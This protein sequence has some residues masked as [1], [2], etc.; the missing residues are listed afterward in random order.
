MKRRGAQLGQL[1]LVVV[2]GLFAGC[3]G[4]PSG[5]DR[6]PASGVL[7]VQPALGTVDA[8]RATELAIHLRDGVQLAADA[9]RHVHVFGR[10]SG[11]AEVTDISVRPGAS[12]STTRVGVDLS[13]SFQA[14]ERVQVTIGAP[15]LLGPGGA[16]LPR[17]HSWSFWTATDP[18]SSGEL[19]EVGRVQVR[20]G[21][22]GRIQ[23]YGGYAGDLDGDGVSDL[24]VPNERSADIRV[25]PGQAGGGF[26]EPTVISVPDGARPS[27]TAGGDFDGDGQVD[28]GVGN[29]GNRYVSVFV[30]DGEG[31]LRHR[32]N[33]PAGNA[34][35]GL[36]A[37]DLESDG[38]TDLVAASRQESQVAIFHNNGSG[39]FER[40]GT[41]EVGRGESGCA[42]GD[43]NE[44]GLPDVFVGTRP[45]GELAVLLSDG[46][47]GLVRSWQG[48][49]Q[50]G[51]WVL[52][53]GDLNGDGHVDV[54][55]VNGRQDRLVTFL[56]DGSG[57][58]ERAQTL[59]V[60]ESFPLAVDMGDL[61]GDGDLDV[62]TSS[63]DGAAYTLFRNDGRGGLS[64]FRTLVA[65]EAGSCTVLQ[66]RDG[67][68][69]LDVTGVDEV[70]DVL[71]L[72]ENQ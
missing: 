60:D 12:D 53:A 3:G 25:F 71:V 13:G 34:V 45:G 18:A 11:P 58:L 72:F 55:S 51:P 20:R 50:G 30:G 62:A 57:E 46:T 38:D 29:I 47:G 64:P 24:V 67:D 33:L 35:R 69:D 70:R 36:C 44:D 9:A 66:D 4:G 43:V 7:R 61:D 39:S 5:P 16:P 65:P 68:G 52:A 48:D 2:A 1:A 41:A 8:P 27:T 28:V 56:G 15:A 23:S 37:L 14:G 21:G 42:V 40:S 19:V 59:V 17:G 49:A 10:W 63:F 22:E 32:T 6:V 26:G 54:V 31:G